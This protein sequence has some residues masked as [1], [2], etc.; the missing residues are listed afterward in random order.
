MK[1]PSQEKPIAN[2]L[3]YDIECAKEH[4]KHMS[5]MNNIKSCLGMKFTLAIYLTIS[6]S[7]VYFLI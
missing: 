5:R 4:D 6:D 1:V 7:L 3:L 2:K